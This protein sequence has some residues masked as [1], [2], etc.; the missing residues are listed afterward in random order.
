MAIIYIYNQLL[1]I[2]ININTIDQFCGL[3]VVQKEGARKT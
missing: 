2:N 3:Q 1:L